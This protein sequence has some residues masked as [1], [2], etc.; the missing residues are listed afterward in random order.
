MNRKLNNE[1][2]ELILETG[3]DEFAG[4]GL[5]RANINVIARKA[6]VSVGVIYKYFGSKDKFFLACV[7]H[8]LELLDK[9]LAEALA[10]DTDILTGIR[11]LIDALIKHAR[12][13]SSYNAMYNEISSGSCR[14]YAVQLANEIETR[15]AAA[16]AKIIKKA[17]AQGEID[18]NI[19]P[20]VFAFLFD[21]LLISLQFSYSCEY[22]RERM[23][24]FCGKDIFEN[25]DRLVDEFMRFM[26]AALKPRKKNK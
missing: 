23:K 4:L 6:G 26:E 7:W 1:K 16:Y 14:K 3:I 17:K 8:S 13:H 9:V 24:I 2:L 21:N 19:D 22:F 20:M 18:P 15:T 5:D 11:N 12:T 25:S 10:E